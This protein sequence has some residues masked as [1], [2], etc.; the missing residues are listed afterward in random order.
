[1]ADAFEWAGIIACFLI[2]GE[3]CYV[4]FWTRRFG[5][6]VTGGVLRA[7]AG[8]RTG[9]G[10]KPTGVETLAQV[11][12][13]D[14]ESAPP[15]AGGFS[16]ADIPPDLIRKASQQF[17]IP[18][19]TVRAYAAQFLGTGN[20][21]GGNGGGA[22]ALGAAGDPVT[23]ALAKMV[24]GQKLTDADKGAAIVSFISQMR[25]PQGAGQGAA[26]PAA[27]GGWA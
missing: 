13:E 2:L 16:A 21:G 12:E 26:P 15:S 17:G 8:L 4:V 1:V 6:A 9:R 19:E 25:S 23:G 10:K 7:V 27:S 11:A 22:P 3:W 14:A 18:E 5:K 20:A 24:S